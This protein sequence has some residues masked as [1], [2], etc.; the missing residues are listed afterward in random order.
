MGSIVILIGDLLG[1]R[2]PVS[3]LAD[4]LAAVKVRSTT[5]FAVPR[6]IPDCYNFR[7]SKT[8]RP[9]LLAGVLFSLRTQHGRRILG[10]DGRGTGRWRQRTWRPKFSSPIRRRALRLLRRIHACLHQP[11]FDRL[12]R[13]LPE[14]RRGAC[15][16][17]SA[18]AEPT[19]D[20]FRL[21]RV[22]MAHQLCR[23]VGGHH[24][25]TSLLALLAKRRTLPLCSRRDFPTIRRPSIS[26][27]STGA[28]H[29][30]RQI[31]RVCFLTSKF[32]AARA[33]VP[34]PI[35]RLSRAS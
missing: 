7:G 24:Q 8:L 17:G 28:A 35:G 26:R 32:S 33:V 9:K 30:S 22:G 20:S 1:N 12:R 31:A 4:T 5:I 16:C 11:R 25:P 19:H 3:N 14:V 10:F 34:P 27:V 2:H 13:Q 6:K 18:R 15:G 21:G 23:T 29:S